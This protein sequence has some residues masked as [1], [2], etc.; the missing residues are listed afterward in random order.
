M[1]LKRLRAVVVL[2][3]TSDQLQGTITLTSYS[4]TNYT[5]QINVATPKMRKNKRTCGFY[6][7]NGTN[8]YEYWV[9]WSFIPVEF[10]PIWCPWVCFPER[11]SIIQQ[12]GSREE[13]E[14]VL[15]DRNGK[16]KLGAQTCHVMSVK[17]W[18]MYKKK[19]R[20]NKII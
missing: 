7:V 8:K 5:K 18:N 20:K 19:K 13:K 9:G 10:T 4:I 15:L 6:L 12:R 14:R 1:H 11:V 2:K 16:P 3:R 17:I